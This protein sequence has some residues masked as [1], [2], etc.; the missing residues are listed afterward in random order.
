MRV[1][2]FFVNFDI[3]E[4]APSLVSLHFTKY[5]AYK[6]LNSYFWILAIEAQF[7]QNG[8]AL[9]K[10]DNDIR[11]D[12]LDY[13]SFSQDGLPSTEKKEKFYYFKDPL[14]RRV[15]PDHIKFIKELEIIP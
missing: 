11:N 6:A 9:R 10:F 13:W 4:S 14:F 5:G 7:T 8:K 12:C 3:Y 1:F 15:N 2:G